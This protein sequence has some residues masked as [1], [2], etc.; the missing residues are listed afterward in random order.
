MIIEE[1]SEVHI[2]AEDKN[3]DHV[4]AKG[5][6]LRQSEWDELTRI[7]NE[8]GLNTHLLAVFGL[9]YFLQ[10][11]RQGKVELPVETQTTIKM[12]E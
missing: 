6:G 4:I 8:H 2:M 9:R 3:I 1:L 11:H 7:A 12:P 10:Q 5:V